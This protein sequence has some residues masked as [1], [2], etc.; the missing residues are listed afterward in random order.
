MI[1]LLSAQDGCC[2]AQLRG[3][4]CPILSISFSPNGDRVS[5][6]REGEEA[7]REGK[8]GRE[9]GRG[10]DEDRRGREGGRW[11]EEEERGEGEQTRT[12]ACVAYTCDTNASGLHYGSQSLCK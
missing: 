3:H 6:N 2:L 9:G 11:G 10:A 12:A 8:A 5:G 1:R 4:D 7:R